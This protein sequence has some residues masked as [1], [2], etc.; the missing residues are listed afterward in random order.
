ML[1]LGC[2]R[3]LEFVFGQA[4]LIG[5]GGAFLVGFTFLNL[6]NLPNSMRAL[7]YQHHFMAGCDPG[8]SLQRDPHRGCFVVLH[9][10]GSSF[11]PGYQTVHG[12]SLGVE[13]GEK[14]EML[15]LEW[16][17]SKKVPQSNQTTP[18]TKI[19]LNGYAA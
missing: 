18:Q 17:P 19:L 2:L 7:G 6:Q 13:M 16:L 5:F 1:F 12:L 8:T 3:A 11:P 15:I 10:A 4:C 14:V 9:P